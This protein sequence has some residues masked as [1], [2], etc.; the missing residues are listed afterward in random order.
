MVIATVMIVNVFNGLATTAW[1]S[2]VFFAVFI[3]PVLVW[4]FTVVYSDIAPGWFYVATYGNNHFL[5]RSV[6]FWFNIVILTVI[7]ILPRY[8]AKA[9]KTLYWPSD[10]D[11]LRSARKDNPNL[12]IWHHPLLG[13]KKGSDVSLSD[14]KTRN[15][16]FSFP[17][18]PSL[19]SGRSVGSRVDMV[20][21]LQSVHRGFDFVTEEDGVSMRRIQSNLSERHA[22]KRLGRQN[23]QRTGS[24]GLFPSLRRSLR[25]RGKVADPPPDSGS[26]HDE[27]DN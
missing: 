24:T 19:H 1:T 14:E 16:A 11:I 15:E 9:A 25:K 7:S 6:F 2:W 18:R 27:D 3:G 22:A 23:K 17:P 5:F 13:G 8:I 21:G 20:T 26:H 4:L 10:V 12:D